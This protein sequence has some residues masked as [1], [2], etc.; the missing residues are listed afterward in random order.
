MA[1][2]FGVSVASADG[3]VTLALTGE[4]DLAGVPVLRDAVAAAA[5][6]ATRR[7]VLDCADLTFIDSSGLGCLVEIRNQ[8]GADG[9][10]LALTNVPPVAAR[11]ITI[12]GLADVLGVEPMS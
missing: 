7:I 2:Q 8:T 9:R 4:L 10:E 12:G 6:A 1:D 3:V 5:S 11:T